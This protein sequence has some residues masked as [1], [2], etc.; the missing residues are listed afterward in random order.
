MFLIGIFFFTGCGSKNNW[1]APDK[2]AFTQNCISEA[3]SS[4]GAEKAKSYCACMMEKSTK[5][6]AQ[7][8][9]LEKASIKDIKA[10][11]QDCIK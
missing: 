8:S 11:A 6:F 4:L 3:T 10:L 7:P 1:S 2:K 9:D 5:K